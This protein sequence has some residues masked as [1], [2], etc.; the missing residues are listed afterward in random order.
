[1]NPVDHVSDSSAIESIEITLIVC[2]PSLTEVEIINILVKLLRFHDMR[3]KDRKQVSL[4]LGE[5]V[6]YGVRKRR[7]IRFYIDME[8]SYMA[9]TSSLLRL[10]C[11]SNTL[12]N[13]VHILARDVPPLS[14]CSA[15]IAR[16]L[17]DHQ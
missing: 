3:H 11:F 12:L 10:S 2:L 7:R 17:D 14:P 8:Q 1:M 4:Q 15:T 13:D 5:L 16:G 9:M 6:F